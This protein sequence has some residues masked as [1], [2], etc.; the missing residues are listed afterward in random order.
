MLW[1]IHKQYKA[2]R[3]GVWS[4]GSSTQFKGAKNFALNAQFFS[5]SGVE[6]SHNYPAT[7]HGGGSVDNLGKQS[8]ALIRADEKFERD[9]IY[10]YDMC[11][12]WCIK[13]YT[14]PRTKPSSGTWGINGRFYWHACSNGKDNAGKEAGYDI[15]PGNDRRAS[16]LPHT[17][18]LYCV[19]TPHAL[20]RK[21]GRN[22]SALS[23]CFVPCY[24]YQARLSYHSTGQF[25]CKHDESTG[26][27]TTTTVGF[28]D[29]SDIGLCNAGVVFKEGGKTWVVGFDGA[30]LDHPDF[31]GDPVVYYFERGEEPPPSQA[32]ML[33][34]TAAEVAKWIRESNK[35]AKKISAG[36]NKNGS[37]IGSA[38][39][40]EGEGESGSESD[41]EQRQQARSEGGT[42][43]TQLTPWLGETNDECEFCADGG[44]L[45]LCFTCCR[46][47]HRRCLEQAK[48]SNF[49]P[50]PADTE[51]EWLCGQCHDIHAKAVES[52][53]ILASI[54]TRPN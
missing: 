41:S 23:H 37:D 36:G 42:I 24:C 30:D 25:S 12:K 47:A 9:R 54:S 34:S 14:S 26:M 38:S 13:N 6:V 8:R 46:V 45:L 1:K 53:A 18:N 40:G 4:D 35:A 33:F 17:H 3:I 28:K 11:Y 10:D 43:A 21:E 49:T 39:E 32:D 29:A 7:A 27:F 31:V 48:Q 44:S 52:Q 19:R 2:S 22:C 20:Q 50:A 5:K 51:G 16:G 15:Q